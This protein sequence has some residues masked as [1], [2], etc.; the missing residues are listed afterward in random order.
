M[1]T[2]VT[3]YIHQHF[4]RRFAHTWNSVTIGWVNKCE[5]SSNRF[6]HKWAL[7]KISRNYFCIKSKNKTKSQSDSSHRVLKQLLHSDLEHILILFMVEIKKAS[8]HFLLRSSL[9]SPMIHGHSLSIMNIMTLSPKWFFFLYFF[10]IE[11]VYLSF[12]LQKYKM[13]T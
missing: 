4:S 1:L 5:P 10:S 3:R 12:A 7:T 6:F 11:F 13:S 8:S 2:Y 9:F